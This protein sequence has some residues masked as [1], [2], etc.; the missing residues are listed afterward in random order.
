MTLNWW[1]ALLPKLGEWFLYGNALVIFGV[2]AWE[3]FK[4]VRKD[5]AAVDS[6]A[7]PVKARV[8]SRSMG[9]KLGIYILALVAILFVAILKFSGHLQLPFALP[10]QGGKYAN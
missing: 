5:S 4:E 1:Y 3:I 6:E 8:L 7:D 9:L 10:L 2:L